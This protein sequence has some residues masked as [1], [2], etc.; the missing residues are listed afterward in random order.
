MNRL[1]KLL[2]F[3]LLFSLASCSSF[4]H[5]D[6]VEKLKEYE[7]NSYKM[8]IDKLVNKLSL[9]TGEMVHLK[10]ETTDDSIKVYALP[11]NSDLLKSQWILVLYMF[12][13]EFPDEDFDFKIFK[14]KFDEI[15]E[16]Q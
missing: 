6:A 5:E 4:V 7:K 15:L 10:I 14:K 16:K 13:G 3:V 12:E 2:L 1:Y 8:K 11:V 9:K